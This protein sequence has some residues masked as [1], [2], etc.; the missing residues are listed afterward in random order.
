MSFPPR[1][2]PAASP[3]TRAAEELPMPRVG[4]TWIHREYGKYRKYGK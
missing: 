1:A 3:A 4:G 2:S